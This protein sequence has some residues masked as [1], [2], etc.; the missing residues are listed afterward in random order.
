MDLWILAP[1]GPYSESGVWHKISGDHCWYGSQPVVLR[2]GSAEGGWSSSTFWGPEWLTV[3]VPAYWGFSVERAIIRVCCCCCSC[4]SD[5]SCSFWFT[6]CCDWLGRWKWSR[7]GVQRH[8]QV[9][10]RTSCR[11]VERVYIFISTLG[12]APLL[13]VI[14]S[15]LVAT[16]LFGL[17]LAAYLLAQ[18][19]IWCDGVQRSTWHIIGHF[20]DDLSQSLDQ[21]KNQYNTLQWVNVNFCPLL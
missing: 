8:C 21:C 13:H 4:R 20:R 14:V 16:F 6:E 5:C 17:S 19:M 18:Y 9:Q 3:W 2:A 12:V 11:Y 10:H 7:A 15:P 1:N